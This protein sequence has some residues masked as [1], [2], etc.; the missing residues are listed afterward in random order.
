MRFI[1]DLQESEK[2]IL[3]RI[4]KES[5]FYRERNR[6]QAILLSSQGHTI[7]ELTKIFQVDRETITRWFDR[8]ETN[9]TSG[10]KDAPGRGRPPKVKPE[11]K[12]SL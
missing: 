4:V 1:T 5:S 7:P 11:E 6:A 2:Q 10:L 12:K 9:R 8:F 3:E